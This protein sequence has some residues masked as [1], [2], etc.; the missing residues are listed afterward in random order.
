[1]SLYETLAIRD[2]QDAADL[3]RAV[4][5]ATARRDGYVSLEVSPL[6]AADTSGT[7]AE[8]RRLWHAV[9][10][11]NL[12]I[13]VPATAAGIPAIRQLIAEGINVNVTLLFA[14][15]AYEDVAE[16]YIDGLEALVAR[17]GDPS[18]VASV[19]SFF[20]SRID[21]AIDT[22]LDGRLTRTADDGERRLLQSLAAPSQSRTRS[23][24][25][26]AISEL[27]SG[28]R[29]RALAGRGAQTQR[30]LWASTGTKNPSLRDV[31]VRR[32]TD[33]ARH[34]QHDAAGDARGVSRPRLSSREPRWR[35]STGAHDTL[36]GLAKA[37]MSLN[38]TTD[39]LLA[40]G[41]DLFVDAFADC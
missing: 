37:G 34:R 7:L 1:M 27:F 25:T 29:W 26:N 2:I 17:G 36:D 21:A 13:K 35:I 28:E 32:R 9:N 11:A 4:Y 24:P 15:Q 31:R 19:A 33:R 23:L 41:I 38:A 14:Q 16:A 22:A 20:V 39:A 18:T 6:L 40:D 5:D 10:R 8:A 3:L 30:L 12:M